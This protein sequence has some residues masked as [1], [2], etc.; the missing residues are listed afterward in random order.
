MITPLLRMIC[1]SSNS[2]SIDT[3]YIEQVVFR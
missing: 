3:V 1:K 2:L